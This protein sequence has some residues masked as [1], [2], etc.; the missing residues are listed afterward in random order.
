MKYRQAGVTACGA[1]TAERSCRFGILSS[2]EINAGRCVAGV[3][4]AIG[5][6]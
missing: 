4:I 1:Q 5:G 3:M 2:E 6:E